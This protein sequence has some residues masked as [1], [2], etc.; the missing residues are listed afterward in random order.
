MKTFLRAT[1]AA[2]F[3]LPGICAASSLDYVQSGS[4]CTVL[5]DPNGGST[6]NL[7]ASFY[8]R[9]YNCRIGSKPVVV[10]NLHVV[11]PPSNPGGTTPPPPPPPTQDVTPPSD[12]GTTSIITNTPPPPDTGTPS[13]SG[14]CDGHMAAVP[15]PASSEM[16]GLGLAVI[17]LASWQ[18][19][20]SLARA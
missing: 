2:L 9:S 7:P 6:D 10:A 11:T 4:Q 17:A 1:A 16:A 15:L 12:G 20:R 14:G 8:Y 18:R 13:G 5:F 3:M 19:S